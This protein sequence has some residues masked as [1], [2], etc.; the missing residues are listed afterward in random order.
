MSNSTSSRERMLA[1]IEHQE[2]DYI[3]LWFNW[4]HRP[5]QI[6]NWDDTVERAERVLDMGLDETML[7]NVP[8]SVDPAVSSKVWVEHACDSRYP[9]IH[10]EWYT[11]K[12]VLRQVVQRTDDWTGSDDVDLIGD[13]NVPRSLQFPV[14][15]L[16]DIEKL[17]CFY[18]PRLDDL[19]DVGVDI[20]WGVDPVQDTTA[21]LLSLSER[22][23][24]GCACWAA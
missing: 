15:G 12:G 23:A 24:A 11:P 22:P 2:P 10:K 6:L 9:L 4:Q 17:D 18:R 20:L 1:T 13:L 8:L 3:P 16:E 14:K 5:T 7:I 21:D 19:M